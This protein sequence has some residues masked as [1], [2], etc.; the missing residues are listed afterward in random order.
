MAALH[1][2]L[3]KLADLILETGSHNVQDRFGASIPDSR[4]YG[5]RMGKHVLLYLH[6]EVDDPT[7]YPDCDDE[8]FEFEGRVELDHVMSKAEWSHNSYN[9]GFPI[10]YH[11]TGAGDLKDKT[12]QAL[13]ILDDHYKPLDGLSPSLPSSVYQSITEHDE[14]ESGREWAW[15]NSTLY[16]TQSVLKRGYTSS[17]YKFDES[18]ETIFSMLGFKTEKVKLDFYD[19]GKS[20]HENIQ[21][22][23][24]RKKIQEIEEK[25]DKKKENLAKTKAKVK[26]YEEAIM[27]LYDELNATKVE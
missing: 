15:N 9:D 4:V 6:M 21:A 13:K 25:I 5:L 24:K 11:I 12:E 18:L 17:A 3:Y 20:L 7:I 10:S 1:R 27:D 22:N 16:L 8:I 2:K 23:K 14:Y 26:R 19:S